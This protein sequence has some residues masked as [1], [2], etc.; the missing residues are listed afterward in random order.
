MKVTG[1]CHCGQIHYEADVDPK[2]VLICHCQDCQTLTGSAFR[3]T[4][5][6][7]PERFRLVKGTPKIYVKIADSGTRRNHAFCGDCGAPVYR[8]PTDN[9]PH[10]SLRIGGLDQRA[11]LGPP[12]KQVWVKRRLPWLTA[13][14][15]VPEIFAQS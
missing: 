5:A 15:E 10:Y 8:M 2:A 13:I 1:K 9:T 3:V 7:A 11:E 6:A 14:S 12:Q 4:V